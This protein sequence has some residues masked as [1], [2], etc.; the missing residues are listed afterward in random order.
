M[1]DNGKT[2][3][4]M[5]KVVKDGK[6]DQFIAGNLKMELSAGM[7]RFILLMVDNTRENSKMAK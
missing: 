6:M 3:N 4:K 2:T 1:K 5:A 7:G